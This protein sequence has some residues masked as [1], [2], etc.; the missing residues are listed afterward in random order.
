M[1]AHK[2][3]IEAINNRYYRVYSNLQTAE[4]I[5]P[6]NWPN[7]KRRLIQAVWRLNKQRGEEHRVQRGRFIS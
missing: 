5:N 1:K 4:D 2:Q 7:T 3:D 6:D